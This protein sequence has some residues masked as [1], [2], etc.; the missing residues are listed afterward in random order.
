[1]RCG[2]CEL[3]LGPEDNYCR[4]C[5]AAV[6]VA[7]DAA[8]QT[9]QPPALVR[10]VA[11]PLASGVAL[12]AAASLLRWGLRLAVR[13][14]VAPRPR[15]QRAPKRSTEEPSGAVELLWYRRVVRD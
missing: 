1:M 11:A 10:S 8:I 13:G 6:R 2:V 3:A 12:V 14:M 7:D 15:S 4:R 5:G 9:T